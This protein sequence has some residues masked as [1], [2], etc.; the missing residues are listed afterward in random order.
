MVASS[1]PWP[2]APASP[3]PTSTGHKHSAVGRISRAVAVSS[4]LS[5]TIGSRHAWIASYACCRIALFPPPP[6]SY[7]SRD[8]VPLSLVPLALLTLPLSPI[9]RRLR[10]PRRL[11]L[12]RGTYA[13]P[14][15]VLLLQFGY[16]RRSQETVTPAVPRSR[17]T[18]VVAL[19]LSSPSCISPVAWPFLSPAGKEDSRRITF[20]EIWSLLA[21]WWCV[22]S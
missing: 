12:R 2:A 11:P 17:S 3:T 19:P 14:Q 20:C 1:V 22:D 21:R 9:C 6:L 18:F 10:Q 15:H 4:T 13:L 5:R 7:F 16:L 8:I